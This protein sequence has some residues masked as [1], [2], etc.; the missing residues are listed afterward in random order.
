V[1]NLEKNSY[2]EE[3]LP[4]DSVA[5]YFE[6]FPVLEIDF[7]FYRMLLNEQGKP[8]P[9][10]ELLKKYQQYLKDD[11]RLILKVPQ[12]IM[13]QKLRQGKN[14][15]QNAAY[16]NPD[17][18]THQ[19]YEPANKILGANVRGFIFEQDYH[20]KQ[21]RMPVEQLAGELDSFFKAIPADQRYHLEIRTPTYL[22]D[23]V[24]EVLDKHGVGQIFSQWTWLPPLRKQFE[25]SGGRIFN[26]GNECVIRLLTPLGM[27]YEETYARAYPFDKLVDEL[28]K[29]VM[30]VEAV[31]LVRE[32]LAQEAVIYLII[33]N[34]AG[35]N[36]PMIAKKVV[37]RF[38]AFGQ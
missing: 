21:D 28:F 2:V 5:E 6:H 34:R 4:I 20:R 32:I 36:A 12:V 14:Y 25:K 33:N 8:T 26:E 37:E 11:D 22:C 15:I 10:Y 30:V 23:P 1:K 24:F 29:P 13:A 16:L 3:V 17:I 19:F 18:F 7:T 38:I 27:R 9:N 35:G 31:N